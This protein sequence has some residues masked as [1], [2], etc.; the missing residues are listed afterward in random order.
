MSLLLLFSGAPQ[1]MTQRPRH[2]PARVVAS[3]AAKAQVARAGNRVTST[4]KSTKVRS[5]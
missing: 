3:G 2:A 5:G 1:T 4:G